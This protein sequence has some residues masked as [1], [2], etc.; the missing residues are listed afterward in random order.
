MPWFPFTILSVCRSIEVPHP[1]QTTSLS[2]LLARLQ[3]QGQEGGGCPDPTESFLLRCLRTDAS[4]AESRG[5]LGVE[6]LPACLKVG[7]GHEAYWSFPFWTHS[8]SVA[9]DLL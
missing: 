4:S 3:V 1:A 2:E 6:T 9:N 8:L 5:V 7:T